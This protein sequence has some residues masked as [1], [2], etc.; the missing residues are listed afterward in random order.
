MIFVTGDLHGLLEWP[1]RPAMGLQRLTA[2]CCPAIDA[3]TEEDFL[4]V[5]GDFGYMTNR[6]PVKR[7]QFLDWFAAQRFTTLFVDGNHENFD[8]LYALPLTERWG[9]KVRRIHDKL[10]HLP[11]GEV[12]ALPCGGQTVTLLAFGGAHSVD[13]AYQKAQGTWWPQEMPTA[14]EYDNARR[15]LARMGNKVDLILTHTAPYEI[16][17]M[18]YRDVYY[19]H[20]L[21]AVLAGDPIPESDQGEVPLNRFFHELNQTVQ[22]HHW[23][24]GHIHEDIDDLSLP[25]ESGQRC[26]VFAQV[27]DALTGLALTDDGRPRPASAFV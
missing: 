7:Q 13:K 17:R 6:L 10:Y 18:F 2:Q 25:S 3:L 15:N 8:A 21:R 23:Y 22:F 9:G 20:L 19:R 27:R 16:T 4:L 14:A 24:I 12:Y 11:R 5:A 26:L 1:D